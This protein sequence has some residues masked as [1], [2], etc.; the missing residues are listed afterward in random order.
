MSDAW[1]IADGFACPLDAAEDF[2]GQAEEFKDA[3]SNILREEPDMKAMYLTDLANGKE[4][5]LGDDDGI[6][7]LME[8]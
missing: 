3:V 8:K 5:S 6:E 2:R 1:T 7:L 4:R